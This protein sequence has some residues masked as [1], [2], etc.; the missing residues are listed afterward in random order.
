MT[1]KGMSFCVPFVGSDDEL[2][3]IVLT[4]CFLLLLLIS[5]SIL[6]V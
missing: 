3:V 6:E 4:G 2:E 1:R 5:L